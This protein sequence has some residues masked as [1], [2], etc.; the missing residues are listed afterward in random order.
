MGVW[1]SARLYEVMEQGT[2][3]WGRESGFESLCTS[4]TL[5]RAPI[6]DFTISDD[7]EKVDDN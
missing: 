5:Y 6:Y 3:Q 1:E 4:R 2:L 7:D